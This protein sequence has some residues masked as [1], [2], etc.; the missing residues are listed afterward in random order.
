[1][2]ETT[3]G[4]GRRTLRHEDRL[5]TTRSVATVCDECGV[6]GCTGEC[7]GV[8]SELRVLV[9][10]LIVVTAF[11]VCPGSIEDLAAWIG[12]GR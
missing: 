10:L 4:S 9:G 3:R 1:M 6:I 2:S 7:A 11:A 5:T 8:A 12:G